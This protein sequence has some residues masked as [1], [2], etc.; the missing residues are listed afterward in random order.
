[1]EAP[2]VR[3]SL[4]LS[5]LSEGSGATEVTV[6]ATLDGDVL[7]ADTEVT[8]SGSGV[9]G[10]VGFAPVQPFV[11]SI[12][13]RHS[14]G[15]AV[16]TL[17]PQ[18]D[19]TAA[20]DETV[21]VSGAAALA[22]IRVGT[23]DLTLID[24][25][26]PSTALLL[27]VVPDTIP[28][29]A[30]RTEV[31]VT[32]LLDGAA[33][34]TNTEV[35]VTLNASG[36]E[37]TVDFEAV[38]PLPFVIPSE[39]VSGSVNFFLTPTNDDLDGAHTTVL[40]NAT[41]GE[42]AP[43]S[44]T[45]LLTDD[46]ETSTRVLLELS[47]DQ[48]ME[49]A[50]AT[51]VT[52]TAR[53]SAAARAQATEVAVSVGGVTAHAADFAPVTAFTLVIPALD[54]E[55]EG[56]FELAP[57]ADAL[58]EADETLAVRGV[59]AGLTV[60]AAHV[61]I[62]DDDAPPRLALAA[63]A[64]P[65]G[66]GEMSF[67]VTLDAPSG[68]EVSVSY[69][70]DDG[71]ALA[72]ADYLAAVGSLTFAPGITDRTFSVTLV[73]DDLYEQ[74][75]HFTVALSDADHATL[76]TAVAEGRIADDDPMP[77]IRLAVVAPPGGVVVEDGGP[78]V[79]TLTGRL[80]GAARSAPTMAELSVAGL[81]AG[82]AD[83]APVAD[84]PLTIAA[85]A[86]VAAAAFT[87]TPVADALH[88][89]D[90]TLTVGS[91]TPGVEVIP[92]TVII[93]DD[94]DVT[95]PRRDGATVEDAALVL[96]Y[97]EALDET[98]V[99]LPGVF[100]VH[101]EGTQRGIS[102]VAVDGTR[103]TLTLASAVMRGEMVTV[104]YTVPSANPIRDLAGNAAGGL[105]A[106]VVSPGTPP[107]V[108]A[109]ELTSTPTGGAYGVGETITVRVT[110]SEAVT[111]IGQPLLALR[112]GGEPRQALYDAAAS[113]G[114]ALVFAYPV[115]PGDADADGIEV[116]GLFTPLDTA[117]VDAVGKQAILRHPGL[118]A[119]S[120]H[121]V[122]GV[123]AELQSAVIHGATLVLTWNET[124]DR[125]APPAA[126][127]FTV[128]AAGALRTVAQVLVSGT[129]ATLTLDQAVR[130]SHA[131]T[132]T[133]PSPCDDS[134]SLL[135]DAAGTPTAALCD[136]A[137]T[138]ETV[139]ATDATLSALMLSDVTLEPQFDGD[140]VTYTAAVEH[141]VR[142]T[143]VTATVNDPYADADPGAD[144]HQVV[145]GVGTNA[146]TVTVT[147]EDR[148]TTQTYTVTVTRAAPPV[149]VAF[150]AG[151]Y[152][153]AEGDSVSVT[154][155]LSAD[156]ERTVAVPLTVSPARDY[157][158][159]VPDS[160]TFTAGET[161]K[162]FTL[163]VAEDRVVEDDEIVTLG[164]ATLLPHRVTEGDPASAAV[165]LED[166]DEPMWEVSVSAMEIAETGG[167]AT[168]TVSTGGVSFTEDKTITLGF[169]GSTAT[170][171]D[172]Y[173]VASET[174]T[175]AV[176]DDSVETMV[177][178][179]SD[180]LD[181]DDE[182][183]A[184]LAS[185]GGN[186][187]G[188][189]QTVTI[190]DDDD[191]P[192]LAI[193]NATADEGDDLIFTVTLTPV[194]GRE[195]TVEWE[196][197]DGTAVVD[198]DYT[199]ASGTLTIA[200]G[201]MSGT[202][203]VSTTQDELDEANETFTVT[204]S[205]EVNAEI[206]EAAAS[207]T[208]EDDD[209]LPS[210]TIAGAS[211][212]EGDDLS[213]EVTLTPASGRA[214]TV[215]WETSDGTAVVDSDYTSASGTLTIAAVTVSTTQDE[216]DEDDE[217]FTVTLSG[218]VNAEIGEAAASGTIEDDDDVPSLT[219]AGA[220]A[221]EG[222]DLSFE[223][224]LTPVS[225]REV[226]VKWETSDGTAV[227]DSD[228]T[229]ASGTLTI[230]AGDT[231]K[232]VTVSTIGDTLDEDDETFTVTLSG[233]VNAEIGEAAASGT[234]ED[235]AA[236]PSLTIADAS[237]TEGDDL[238]F[239]VTLTPASGR[240]VTVEWETSDGTAVVDSDYTSASGTLTIAAGD[241]SGTVTV[242][243]TEDELDEDDETFTVT[244]S[245]PGNAGLAGGG[246]TLAVTGT[247]EDADAEPSLTIAGVEAYEGDDLSFEVTLTP[248]SGREVTVK[249]ETS[250]GTAVAGSDYTAVTAGTLTIA[251]G[252]TSGAVTV[253]TTE[254][255]LDEDD[256]T[257]TV[258]LSN[259]G[260]AGLAGGGTTLAATG[261]IEDDD[262][263]PSLT[264]ADATAEEGAALQFEVTLSLASS[265]AVTVDYATSNGTAVAGSDYTSASGT[266][267]F[268]AGDTTK[269]VTVST[270][271]DELD[272]DDETFTF[273]LSSP[274][275]AGLAGGDTTLAATGTIED[276]DTRG[277]II[278][279]PPATIIEGGS[280]TY[281]VALASQ[282]TGTVTVTISGHAGTDVSLSGT[283]NNVLTFTT[284]NWGTAQTVTVNAAADADALADDPVTLRHAASG[285]DYG[286]LDDVTVTVTVTENDTPTLSVADATA[287]EGVALQFEV[288]LSLASG[289]AVTV[290]HATSDGTA[291]AGSDY[292]S[293]SGTLTIAAGDTS[294]TV[295]VSTTQDELDEDDE[296]FTF[297][298]SSPV[299]AGLAGGGAMLAA[300]G[301]I[302][303]AAAEPSL[304]LADAT[305]DEGDDLSFT[306][307]LGTASGRAVTVNYATSD[308]TAVAGS[309]Y[310][311]ASGTLTFAAGDMTKTVTVSTTEDELDEDDET[312]TFTLS[313]PGNAGLAGGDTTLAATGTI[314]DDDT[315]GIIIDPPPATIIEGG[316]A[317]YTVVLAS[318]P[319]GTVTVTISGHAGTDVSLSGTTNNVLTFTT[320]NWDTAQTVT[321][322][323][324][325]DIDALADDPVTLTHTASGGDYGS[326][327][328]VTVTVTVTENDTPT[329][330]V[331]D[332]TA[333]EGAALQFEV[334]LSLASSN[335]VTVNHAT[336][337]GTAV[338]GSDYT[339]ASGTLTFAA[340]DTTKTVT[341]STTEDELDEDDE[342]FT[343]TLSSPGNAGLAGGGTTLAA[344]GTIEDDDTRGIIIDPPPAT[345]I[346]G[347]SATY[348]VVLASQ[349]TGTVTVT[350]SGHAGT[351]VSLSGTTNNVLTF[352]TANWGTAQT[353]TVNAAADIDALADAT[354]EEGVALQFE[355]T[356]SLASSNAVTVN[357]ATSDGTAVAGSDYTSVSGTL[358]IA[359]GDTSGTV[360]VST[361][362]DELDEDDETFT[363]TLS[364][365]VNAG[366][367]GGG[368]MLAATGTIEDAAAEPSLTLADATADEGD[369][370]SF[371]VSLGTASGR[372]VTVNYA[373]SDGTAVAGSDYTA[374]S[375]TLTFAAGDMTKT[376]TVSTTEDELDEDDE[377]FTFTLSSPGNAGLAGG[378]TTLA[379]TGTITDNDEPPGTVSG[380]GLAI[381]DASATEGGSV[382]FEVTLTP[383][384]GREVTVDWATSDGTAAAG[385]D[386]T[387]ASGSLAFAA[388]DTAKTVTVSTTGDTLDEDD[389]TFTVTLSNP[390]NALVGD[391]AATGT[392]TDDDGAVPGAP[393][394]LVA[395]PG[396][397]RV[398]VCWFGVQSA[399]GY[400]VQWKTGSESF[401]DA[402]Q[403][404]LGLPSEGVGC[405]SGE[406]GATVRDLANG[407]S[408]T[409]RVRS[410]RAWWD[411]EKGGQLETGDWSAEVTGTPIAV[412][413]TPAN[414][415]VTPGDG[416]L[417]LAWDAVA[418]AES[419]RVEWRQDRSRRELTAT[420]NSAAITELEN[421]GSYSVRV[422]AENVSGVSAYS[423][424]ARG[425][426][427]P[428]GAPLELTI[429]HQASSGNAFVVSFEFSEPVEGF[430]LDD[431]TASYCGK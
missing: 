148:L 132:V 65:E 236:E 322:N 417:D 407:T 418:G 184:V 216:L 257:F 23:A 256:E 230:A 179:V 27:T 411:D 277:I 232:T 245:N 300:T 260:N 116:V 193:G 3:L 317:T 18:D 250:D 208:I 174:L 196:T 330:S 396:A 278:D 335:A 37:G 97:N 253:S 161:S 4:S 58:H 49:S 197:S 79:V 141:Y 218:E 384:S 125:A 307:S 48:I 334:T 56:T 272:E 378:D 105:D 248:V 399:T 408:Y 289:N 211:A 194:S 309:D 33:S 152:V 313:S 154:V 402:R 319:T 43:G 325:A 423:T 347:G 145:L 127:A 114:A 2:E 73:D 426:P 170:L 108:H 55:A 198:S 29:G 47:V 259:P 61:T 383:V 51:E 283:T 8:V 173:T 130:R 30:G 276:D 324:A 192:S 344:T 290:N 93:A 416:R 388:G 252:D 139:P 26:E 310:T 352:T 235:D 338:A 180:A 89:P 199:S 209:D 354:A 185:H 156:P 356:L 64:A 374:A 387:A 210:L 404:T 68:R 219:I 67:A 249:W 181:E 6:T 186:T 341:V 44:A 281:T 217:T 163:T 101:V 221:T 392:I 167:T 46:D 343:F 204:L 382:S 138:N 233:A 15:A 144:G 226:T 298:L 70:T 353:V 364:S 153:V 267:T 124:L 321:V 345:I 57:V 188:T 11:V 389:E 405:G 413:A 103:V 133:H 206:G 397:G 430:E 264:L 66:A 214:V 205:G 297:T 35:A 304:T 414:I 201:D 95:P 367:A 120:G 183:I 292:T 293:V 102:A 71:T 311:A 119:Q 368:A 99:P 60:P 69:A 16:F 336:S 112:V 151:E 42:L 1:M 306:V 270:T 318:Q 88:E 106:V 168:V 137:V 28:E 381:A 190:T 308:G 251:A 326:L 385:S 229:S 41:A 415:V 366:L 13:A 329:L 240:A 169:G 386:Y 87:L 91:A 273:T 162:T 401:S 246:T 265:N 82:D 9:P 164:F 287:E 305:A 131:V 129:T 118:A 268:A 254:D 403:L 107:V 63:A 7:P 17:T 59:A 117:I 166:D 189:Q 175:L 228:Y 391:A 239:E 412:P 323:A 176:G 143:T 406:S 360:T 111:A 369:D 159:G 380:E 271:E 350:I 94:D 295:T 299:N 36:T 234:I 187:I 263:E 92:A 285:G 291:V 207:G 222:D 241:T 100:T 243:T 20:A 255:E 421:G 427:D 83:F 274:G 195:V 76:E 215:E 202:V 376:V 312:F 237:A 340:G 146:I 373:T 390:G 54:T 314:E 172:D 52:V 122:D 428:L 31:T 244:L 135:R 104:T 425:T 109:V 357:H 247:I 75:E 398:Y 212:T 355:V 158:S 301:T 191:L 22:W 231:T 266:L 362:Q 50:A 10:V 40:V 379:A 409:F 155:H 331:A 339:S 80:E 136:E 320:A 34:P 142:D 288:T 225:G 128:T 85:G 422:R 400:D 39:A 294:G 361:T 420:T 38:E 258:T 363:F 53:L 429:R 315:R 84:F 337:D 140:I 165:T 358:T 303:D 45:L 238:S 78:A 12:P 348:T 32:A 377:T 150:D 261:T 90:E 113:S 359:A 327:D 280:A 171:T 242:S 115:A 81:T 393:Q 134:L 200:A 213:F 370:L 126:A 269:T 346:E 410:T 316:S 275:N 394:N 224:T 328:D 98:S 203:T 349:P 19:T 21:T 351:D 72:P 86:T 372:A 77:R 147:A 24:N 375:G 365:P 157:V 296:T 123:A 262:A 284:A 279:P 431:I 182:I 110:F 121:Q 62:V 424:V 223:V 149:T 227:M 282:P 96:T 371:T 342:T 333:E 302:E 395:T 177:T 25:D 286:S 220:S 332:A 74:G 14:S 160:L 178:A 419:Y 5:E